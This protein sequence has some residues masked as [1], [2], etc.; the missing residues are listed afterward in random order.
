MAKQRHIGLVVFAACSL[1]SVRIAVF[2]PKPHELT[3][4]EERWGR[5][6]V[7][8]DHL[9][10]V[11]GLRYYIYGIGVLGLLIFAE[12]YVTDKLRTQKKPGRASARPG[13]PESFET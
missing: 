2:E 8:E 7:S 5:Q 12:D 11:H 6:D 3:A 10:V 1:L 13:A 9:G 4:A